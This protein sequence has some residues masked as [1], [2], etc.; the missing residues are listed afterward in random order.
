MV[1]DQV[2]FLFAGQ[3]SQYIGMG[4]EL[5]DA[6]PESK[7]VFDKADKVL[8]FSLSGLCFAGSPEMLKGT[9]ISQ[10]AILTVSI[11]ALEAFKRISGAVPS[12]LAGLSLGEYSALIAAGSLTFEDGLKLVKKR[13]EIMDEAARRYPGKMAAVL[14]L[15]F[16]QVKDIC[17]KTGAEIA[18]INAPSQLVIS[19]KAE[20]V[21]KA[22]NFCLEAGAKRVIELE[23]S[24]GFHSSLMLE[25]SGEL[26]EAL[27]NFSI[28]APLTPVVSNYTAEPE[29]QIA[30][31]RENLIYQMYSSVKWDDSMKFILS[32]GIL[33]FMEFG[34]GRV[35][36]GLM[37]RISAQAQVISIEKKEDIL[38]LAG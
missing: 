1:K 29:Y 20:S 27:D 19:G 5:Y 17:L 35:L 31:I 7:A 30:Q 10:P 24:G 12:F 37:R 32:K 15:P 21:D 9:V 16:E 3:G 6:F 22:A 11:A 18:N 25:A 2:A 33:N 4:K 26:K 8:G 14:G 36:K 23:V 38:S 34:P 28:S 13:A